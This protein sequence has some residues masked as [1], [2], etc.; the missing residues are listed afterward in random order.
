MGNADTIL[1][2]EDDESDVILLKYQFL[3]SKVRNPL[4]VVT[5]GTQALQYLNGEAGYDDR[6]RFPYP[7]LILLDLKMPGRDGFEVLEWMQS[8]SSHCAIPTIVVT[9]FEE[10][11][12]TNRA[13]QL[14]ARSFLTKPITIPDFVNAL[15]AIKGLQFTPI[16]DG[17]YLERMP[18]C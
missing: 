15:R 10:L 18:T 17:F 12:Q 13:Y 16:A 5:N 11:A 4:Q 14:G 2:A 6:A 9:H 1:I 7:I 8:H 3:V